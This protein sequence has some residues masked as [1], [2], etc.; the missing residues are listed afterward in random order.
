MG[1]LRWRLGV[2]LCV[3]LGTGYFIYPPQERINLGLDLQGGIHLV[4]EV[5]SEKAVESKVERYYNDI[6]SALKQKDVRLRKIV[7]KGRTLN[8]Q[9]HREND[10]TRF[11]EFMKE[12]PDFVTTKVVGN[13]PVFS[14]KISEKNAER[15]KEQA[16]EQA[17]ET[18][19]NR[20]D[21][22][23]VREPT[24]QRQ[25]AKRI[26]I[27]LPGVDDPAR[28]K[29]LIGKTALLEFK[30]VDE[31]KN[32]S[33]VV[34]SGEVPE[35]FQLIYDVRRD[36]GT[37]RTV[38]G[39]PYLVRRESSLTGNSLTDARATIGD[40]FNEP[41][42]SITFDK[43]GSDIFDRVTSNNVGRRLAI[44]LDG[45]VHSAPTIQE[46]ISQGQAQITGSFTLE[47]AS[48]LAITLRAGALPAPV[49]VLEERNVGPSLG[50]DSIQSGI[51][52]IITGFV[53]VLI[54]MAVYYKLSGLIAILALLLNL[55]ILSG[56]L[57]LF[58]A[59]LTLP[60]IAGIVLTVG[61]AVD[62]NVL[63]FERIREELR[64]G[65]TVRSAIDYGFGKAFLTI[66]DANITTLIAA[67]VLLQFG[68]G[69]IKGFAVTLSIGI[70]ASMFTAIFCTRFVYDSFLSSKDVR[71]LSI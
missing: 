64:L 26:I 3:L 5:Q 28:A 31:T 33:Q 51:I 11:L 67:L 18:I 7:A 12:Y 56:A 25:G 2:I 24:L 20:I 15:I 13:P 37:G 69:P 47:E 42:V 62:A 50:S 36:L 19:R 49:D 38:K 32:V 66:L 44:V 4:L 70:V 22:F 54:F 52:S 8:I 63:I 39:R 61:M 40:R 71:S 43:A 34:E 57:G 58:G 29:A 68:T 21:Q 30:M 35:G 17:L 16:V 53:L 55:F 65:K 41:Y 14:F 59:T 27:Q 6:K 23:G 45:V 10:K 60:G 48:D 9:I 1:G 46:R